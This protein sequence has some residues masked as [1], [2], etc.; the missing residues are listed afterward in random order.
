MHVPL[1]W[2]TGIALW[3]LDLLDS[4]RIAVLANEALGT[5][6]E[7]PAIRRI[8]SLAGESGD[9]R[10]LFAAAL[11]ELHA[12]VPSRPAAAHIIA[13][14]VAT[15]L[16][17]GNSDPFE[18]ARTLSILSR[19][20]GPGFH[21]LDSFVYAESEAEDRP[22]DRDFFARAIL[23]EARRWAPRRTDGCR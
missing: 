22:Q 23:D 3:A 2:D 19:A 9:L 8:T 13:A 11:A 14:A 4:D 21:E 1:T 20:V 7:S 17:V 16:L 18:A 5:E 12:A 15:D 10:E 6:R